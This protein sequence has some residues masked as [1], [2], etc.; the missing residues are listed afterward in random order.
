MNRL[1]N[2]SPWVWWTAALVAL[3]CHVALVWQGY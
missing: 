2:L 1:L 3:A